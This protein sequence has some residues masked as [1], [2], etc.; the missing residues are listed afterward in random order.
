[1]NRSDT[2]K[3]SVGASCIRRMFVECRLWKERGAFT[4]KCDV[5]WAAM[6][7]EGSLYCITLPRFIVWF[8]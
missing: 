6:R 5:G 3:V 1:V 4:D 2:V 8:R 7:G